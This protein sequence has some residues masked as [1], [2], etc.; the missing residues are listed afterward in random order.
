VLMTMEVN[1]ETTGVKRDERARHE[2]H[3]ETA[4][5]LSAA[6]STRSGSLN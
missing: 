5:F 1:I 2:R 4:D 3:A 6:V